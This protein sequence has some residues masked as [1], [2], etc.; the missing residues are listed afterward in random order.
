MIITIDGP[1]ASG[2]STIARMTAEKL[3]F[4]YLNTGLLYRA[5]TY[6]LMNQYGYTQQDLTAVKNDDL[7]ACTDATRFVYSY[8]PIDG[9]SVVYNNKNI[10]CFLKDPVIDQCVSL[11]SPQASVREA[12][13][14]LQRAIAHDHDVVVE[15]RDVGSVVFPDADYKLYLTASLD[16]RGTRW[17]N[18]QETKG[19]NYSLEEA[20]DRI[21]QRDL[22]DKS[23]SHSPLIIPDQAIIIDNSQLSL[24]ESVQEILKH[25]KK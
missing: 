4:Y 9:P 23:R 15:G 22:Q 19:N 5:V 16:V 7:V 8:S 11:I 14:H 25:I 24:E 2:K 20:K 3:T 10:T 6:L 18:Y 12:L 13:S 21:G 1:A 17:K